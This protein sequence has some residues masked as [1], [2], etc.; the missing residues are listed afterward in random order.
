M[1]V[2]QSFGADI[3]LF[4]GAV[5]WGLG[6]VVPGEWLFPIEALFLYVGAFG[7]IIAAVQIAR[8]GPG[9]AGTALRAAAPWL[10]LI[11]ALLAAGLAIL[12]QPMEMRGT[13]QALG[14]AGG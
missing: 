7:S 10:V 12:I 14:G 5:Q 2:V 11:L 4:R 6:L 13:F 3:G 9:D 8:Q 1:P